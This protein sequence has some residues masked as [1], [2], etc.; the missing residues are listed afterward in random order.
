MQFIRPR[1]RN[2]IYHSPGSLAVLGRVVA[3][4]NREFLDRVYPQV[5][6]QDAPWRAIGVIVEA[7]AI[8]AIVVLLGSGTGNG[9]LLAKATIPS[10]RTGSKIRLGMNCINSWLQR[11]Q[12]GPAAAVERQLTDRGCV[13]DG[14]D[15]GSAKLDCRSFAGDFYRL[16]GCPHIHG[17]IHNLR[18][19]HR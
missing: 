11:C 10:V 8:Q 7:D 16:D 12:V 15:V 1:A 9:Q 18:R 19:S 17:R 5:S 2:R 13:H 6:S 4:K 3:R 14:A